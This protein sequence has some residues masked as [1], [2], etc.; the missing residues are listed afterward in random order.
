MILIVYFSNSKETYMQNRMAEALLKTCIKYG[1]KAID[2][3]N[4]YE[5]ES[6]FLNTFFLNGY[7]LKQIYN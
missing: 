2:N 3:R 4:N 7:N 6:D 5:A 1:E